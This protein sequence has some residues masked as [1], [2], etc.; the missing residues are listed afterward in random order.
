MKDN[1]EVL[2]EEAGAR[3]RSGQPTPEEPDWPAITTRSKTPL[4]IAAAVVVI[5]G[6]VA[7]LLVA[8]TG[9]S[10]PAHVKSAPVVP[11][12][13]PYAK[14][15]TVPAPLVVSISHPAP[16][17]CRTTELT[18]SVVFHGSTGTLAVR[19]RSGVTEGCALPTMVYGDSALRFVD[20][21]GQIRGT[22]INPESMFPTNPPGFWY[23]VGL[24]PGQTATMYLRAHGNASCASSITHAQLRFDNSTPLTIPVTGARY[25]N[26]YIYGPFSTP[27]HAVAFENPG[28]SDLYGTLDFPAS[29]GEQKRITYRIT[30]ANHG[31]IAVPL[32]P[33]T[34]F[35]VE[36]SNQR[37]GAYKYGPI[38]CDEDNPIV[39]QPGRSISL[40]LSYTPTNLM[41]GRYN[42]AWA[43]AGMN[44]AHAETT[45]R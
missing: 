13:V 14:G 38:G 34:K 40:T 16:V 24:R 23:E 6:V 17:Y 2:L 35:F 9:R 4:W 7:A 19:L 27:G 36:L 3:W 37:R 18:G 21:A 33:C 20:Q 5:A 44:T 15:A 43:I 10:V 12:L 22:G 42:V 1:V 41:S 25:C 28:W 8:G 29:V 32:Q 26:D 30:L 31:K 39:I 45:V 11:P